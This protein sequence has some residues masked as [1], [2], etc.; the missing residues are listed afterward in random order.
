MAISREAVLRRLQGIQDPRSYTGIFS[1]GSNV[2][3]S[4]TPQATTGPLNVGSPN[5]LPATGQAI[6]GTL[7]WQNVPVQNIPWGELPFDAYYESNVRRLQGQEAGLSSQEE[8]ARRRLQEGFQSGSQELGRSR[9]MAMQGLRE[10]MAD[11]GITRSGIN[12]Q[13][14]GNIGEE[15]LRGVQGLEGERARSEEDLMRDIQSQREA[16]NQERT[17]YD[18]QRARDLA[19]MRLEEARKQAMAEAQKMFANQFQT[20]P[21]GQLV[22]INMQGGFPQSGGIM[23]GVQFHAAG[24]QDPQMEAVLRK[25]GL[26]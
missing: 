9:D 23:S 7:P 19:E 18:E 2:Y 17:A 10:R 12:I 25:L 26:A 21:T 4:G 15:Y 8:I 24:A 22:P 5:A 16:L 20:T 14:Q 3:N 6:S 11:Q 1:R 13:E